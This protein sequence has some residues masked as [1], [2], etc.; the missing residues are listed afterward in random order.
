MRHYT[1][2]AACLVLGLN[3]AGCAKAPLGAQEYSYTAPSDEADSGGMDGVGQ[4]EQKIAGREE[5][6]SGEAT[7]EEG[8]TGETGREK[9]QDDTAGQLGGGENTFTEEDV[10]AAILETTLNQ[11]ARVKVSIR[12]DVSN[13]R[14][15][16][17]VFKGFTLAYSTEDGEEIEVLRHETD[18]YAS[19]GYEWK[20]S[21]SREVD[22]PAGKNKLIF[23][24][25]GGK[26]YKVALNVKVTEAE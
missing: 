4:E 19:G 18:E 22:L 11:A 26:N 1:V 25:N 12:I 13:M 9:S 14:W 8:A 17:M 21:Y 23:T 16:E 6:G 5:I 24:A 20:D 2:F 15:G 3:L 7:Q 10:N